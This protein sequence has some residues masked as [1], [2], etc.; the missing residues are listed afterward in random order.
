ME[1]GH[2]GTTRSSATEAAAAP[3]CSDGARFDA[4][5]GAVLRRNSEVDVES[6]EL[7]VDS[8]VLRKKEASQLAG[9]TI[10]RRP[11]RFSLLRQMRG[12]DGLGVAEAVIRQVVASVQETAGTRC[13][14]TFVDAVGAVA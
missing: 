12:L 2:S 8:D 9:E 5:D 11:C 7:V 13:R 4:S 6:H 1:T 3:R 14:R 10:Q